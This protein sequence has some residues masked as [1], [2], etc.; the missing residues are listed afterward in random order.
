M[1]IEATI[2]LAHIN[3]TD[4]FSSQGQKLFTIKKQTK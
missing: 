1:R 2:E 3:M 4:Q